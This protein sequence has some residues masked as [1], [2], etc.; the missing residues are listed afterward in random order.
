[1]IDVGLI[2]IVYLD[3]QETNSTREEGNAAL[4]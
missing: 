4:M 3:V 2:E 1:M